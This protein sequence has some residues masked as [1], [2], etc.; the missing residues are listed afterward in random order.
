[1]SKITS[2]TSSLLLT[3]WCQTFGSTRKRRIV[4]RLPVSIC[5]YVLV[6]LLPFSASPVA[7]EP[8][9]PFRPS[10]IQEGLAGYWRLNEP[11]GNSPA[12]DTS[13]NG[14]TLATEGNPSIASGALDE[15]SRSFDG[16]DDLLYIDHNS[17]PSLHIHE[18]ATLFARVKLDSFPVPGQN[19]WGVIRKFNRFDGETFGWTMTL[20]RGDGNSTRV[21]FKTGDGLSSQLVGNLNLD[22]NRWYSIA[23]VVSGSHQQIYVDG[24]LDVESPLPNSVLATSRGFEIGRGLQSASYFD[25][26]IA[27]A[28][29]WDA[30]LTPEQI[31][32]LT[33]TLTG[34][35]RPN[36]LQVD[37]LRGYWPLNEI[38]GTG[39]AL[40]ESSH[41]NDLAPFGNPG[42]GEGRLD[43]F[44]R[45]FDGV[46]D[47]LAIGHSEAPSL[48][49][50]GAVTLFARINVARYPQPGENDWGIIEKFATVGGQRYGWAME[51]NRGNGQSTVINF[52]FGDGRSDSILG[53]TTLE[54]G[55]WYDIACV[56]SKDRLEIYV[57]GVLDRRAPHADATV[58][59]SG[60]FEIGNGRQ[61]TSYYS[62]AIA[63]AAVWNRALQPSEIRA[64]ALVDSPQSSAN[65]FQWVRQGGGYSEDYGLGIAT[66]ENGNVYSTGIFVG[67]ALFDQVE[68]TDTESNPDFDIF[69]AKYDSSGDIQWARKAGGQFSDQ[70]NGITSDASGNVYVT[71]F[72]RGSA[73]FES[74]TIVSSG[75]VDVF[76]AK[77]S[78]DGD[79]IWVRKAGGARSDAGYDIETDSGGNIYVSGTFYDTAMFGPISVSD[80]GFAGF[81]AK[82]DPSGEPVWVRKFGGPLSARAKKLAVDPSGNIVITGFFQGSAD[83]GPTTVQSAGED[84]VFV[85]KY[86]NMGELIWV[87]AASGTGHDGGVGI[88]TDQAGNIAVVGNITETTE[89][90]NVALTSKGP[91][92]GFLVKLDPDGNVLWVRQI[93]SAPYTTGVVFDGVGDMCVTGAFG[94]TVQFETT[95]LISNYGRDLFLAKYDS[96]GNFLN[97]LRVGDAQGHDIAIDTQGNALITG[98]AAG[99]SGALTFGDFQFSGRGLE[100]FFIAK[101][102]C[103]EP[104]QSNQPPTLTAIDP[105]EGAV[106]DVEF[107][108]SY[109]LHLGA[110]DAGDPDG[111][112]LQFRL[113]SIENGSL[114]KVGIEGVPGE[115]LLGPGEGWTWTPSPNANGLVGAFTITVWDGEL[116][117]DTPVLVQ[118]SVASVNDAPRFEKGSDLSVFEDAGLQIIPNWATEIDP[119]GRDD[120]DQ[121]L[122]FS[123]QVINTD[124]PNLFLVA[125]S[126]SADGILTYE[127]A[128]DASGQATMEVL[129]GDDG[130]TANGG[131]N[132]SDPKQF[133]ITVVPLNDAPIAVNTAILATEDILFQ[134]VLTGF[135]LEA[136]DLMF[137][138]ASN[139]AKG[140]VSI[141]SNS[142]FAY[143]PHDDLNGED[144]FTFTVNDGQL[145]SVPGTVSVTI[146]EVNDPP[147]ANP[148]QPGFVDSSFAPDFQLDGPIR[149]VAI[150]DDGRVLIGGD[151]T[152]IDGTVRIG[153]ARLNVDGSLDESFDPGLNVNGTVRTIVVAKNGGILV[154]G[155]LLYSGGANVLARLNPDGSWDSTFDWGP[156]AGPNGEIKSIAVQADGRILVA[157][158]F[159]TIDG[160]AT[161]AI[162]RLNTDGTVDSSFVPRPADPA[163]V[164]SVAAQ[165]D[166][167]VLIGGFFT[168]VQGVSRNRIARLNSDGSL[169][170]TFDPGDGA[171]SNIHLMKLQL[172]GKVLIGGHFST[173]DSITRMNVARLN[174]DGSLDIGFNPGSG[175]GFSGQRVDSILVL[176]G[177]KTLIGGTF[178]FF[179]GV[180]RNRIARL[181]EDG[182]VD[183]TYDIGSGTDGIVWAFALS[184][185][186]QPVAAG[187]FGSIDGNSRTG[188]GKLVNEQ[189]QKSTLEDSSLSFAASELTAN[190][191]TGPSDESGQTLTVISV[192]DPSSQG[193]SVTLLGGTI[194]Y[195]PAPEFNGVDS[196]AYSVTDDGTT[197]GSPDPKTGSSTVTIEVRSSNDP[198]DVSAIEDTVLHYTENDGAIAMTETVQVIDVDDAALVSATVA[199][200][201]NYARNQDI[202]EFTPIGNISGSFDPLSGA[203]TLEGADTLE[204]Y[205]NVLRS[206][207]YRNNS[208]NPSTL[209]RTLAFV[210]SDG[211]GV[212]NVAQR[213]IS[214]VSV[215]DRPKLTQ[216][217]PNVRTTYGEPLVVALAPDTFTDPEDGHALD[218]S[219]SGMP[220]GIHFDP[221]TRTFS[222]LAEV[223]DQYPIRVVAT[224]HGSPA[225]NEETFFT[226]DISKRLLD[227][228]AD[229]IGKTYDGTTTATVALSDDRIA[230][231]QL[232]ASYTAAS[233]ADKNVAADKP[234]TVTGITIS[235]PDAGNYTAG[236]TLVIDADIEPAGLTLTADAVSRSYGQSNPALTA[237]LSG[238]V[239]GESAGV[240]S[241]SPGFI[242]PT[243]PDSSVGSYPITP[244]LGSLTALNYIFTQFVGGTLTVTQAALTATAEDQSRTYRSSNPPLSIHYSGFENG[245]TEADLDS[246]PVASTTADIA[247]E[248]G[249]YS[250]TLTGGSDN[251]Y[252]LIL[253]NGE[254]S[255]TPATLLI[256]ADDK[257]KVY[258]AELPELTASYE[259]FVNGE[260]P[261]GLDTPV[262]FATTASAASSVGS[263]PITASEAQDANYAIVFENGELEVTKTLL[264]ATADDQ[265]RKYGEV[266]PEL[267]IT[268]SGFV[269]GDTETDVDT[270][271][272]ASTKATKT[273]P[274]DV[275]PITVNGGGDNNYELDLFP[276]S[277]RVAPAE[278][279][280]TADDA[281]RFYG[282]SNLAFTATISGFVNG[283]DASMVSG[284]PEFATLATPTS[285]ARDYAITPSLGTLS[286]E[287]YVF[288]NF[289]NGTLVVKKATLTATA[290]GKS[291]T[292]GSEN[293]LLTISY[294]GFVNGD[295]SALI[296]DLPIAS[297][298][299]TID[300]DAGIYPI[301]LSGGTDDN[302]TLMLNN[303][304]FSIS[305]ANLL[306]SADDKSNVYGVELPEL[307]ASYSG[308][309]NGDGPADLDTP[310]RL[311]TTASAASVVGSYP[312]MASDAQDANYAIVFEDG[313][314]DVTKV[315]LVTTA[316]GQSRKYGEINPELTITYSG[317]VNGDME[318]DIDTL[319][320]ASTLATIVS[321]VGSYPITLSGGEDHNYDLELAPGTLDVEAA[322]LTA[323]ADDATRVYGE[324]NRTFTATITGFVNGEDASVVSGSPEFSTLAT[325]TSP[326]G[327]YTI[328]PS[329]GTLSSRN[330]VFASFIDGTLVVNKAT[331]TATADDK[332]RIYGSENPLLTISYSGFVNGDTSVVLDDLP[333][334]STSATIDSDAGTYPIT[335]SGGADEDYALTLENGKLTITPGNLRI[336]ADDKSKVYGA[337]LPELTASFFGF[338]NGDGPS[339]LDTPVRPAT[340]ASA[341]SA[342]GG[343]PITASEAKDANYAI[344]FEDGELEV[345]KALLTATA[346]NQ[347]RKYGED[348]P[349]LTITY[350]GFV[351]GDTES[352]I[353]VL[354]I[355]ATSAITTSLVGSYPI[356][357]S[358]GEDNNYDLDRNPGNLTVDPAKLT[359][360]ADDTRRI[361]GE[362]NP[363]FT[364]TIS[365]FVNGEDESVVSGSAVFST[366]A[367]PASPAG[368]YAIT[369]S[370]GT[371]SAQNYALTSFVDGTLTV[372][373]AI[374]TA[375]ADGKS[376]TYGSENPPL[377]ISY[378]GF[379]NGN[380]PAELDV[381]PTASTIA[382][383]SSPVEDYPINLVGGQDDNY[384]LDLV[385]GILKVSPAALSVT[386]DDKTR[387]V[388]EPNPEFS[389]TI[390][391]FVNGEALTVVSGAPAFSTP[392]VQTG[393]AG[394][395][396]IAPLLGT[397]NSQNYVFSQ[398]VDGGLTV[399]PIDVLLD[400]GL[401]VN[402][403]ANLLNEGGLSPEAAQAV[404]QAIDN[405]IGNNGGQA[406][407]GATDQ[408]AL[409][410]SNAALV[411]LREAIQFLENAE[412]A[413]TSLDFTSEK[414][415]L[416]LTGGAVVDQ[417]IANGKQIASTPKDLQNIEAAESLVGVGRDLIYSEDFLGSINFFR[418][419]LTHLKSPPKGKKSFTV[420]GVRL[421][422]IAVS[423]SPDAQSFSFRA[424]APA[425]F[426]VDF[427]G[428]EDLLEWDKIRS[429]SIPPSGTADF[430]IDVEIETVV[431]FYRLRWKQLDL[432]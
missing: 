80:L 215:N 228:G 131:S 24:I 71:G 232:T 89:F 381:L 172:D 411:K 335:L 170:L 96:N 398:F 349:E 247:S 231:D 81:L 329:Q 78:A 224:D 301:T 7:A 146:S 332:S 140:A 33:T 289:V 298:T 311:A 353:N 37:Q 407:N 178:N 108:V 362:S 79:L 42:I 309:I 414:R 368:N 222:G 179:D 249:T 304:A 6:A 246:P 93:E 110:T 265:S 212:S 392:A 227:V 184:P 159:S 419:A 409:E 181:N 316:D 196:F 47:V 252:A 322:A 153:L 57:N 142:Q 112:S 278:L 124:N 187:E 383:D 279:T 104:V 262:R 20:N 163:V 313:E 165:P 350:S 283:E 157:G 374:L 44:S 399:R 188:V 406:S 371:L 271:P 103:G 336:S 340:T 343:Y 48:Q 293:P 373:K 272:T 123:V 194:H 364:T 144:I 238:F 52:K 46:D 149:A 68:L 29:V 199:I 174:S 95:S 201:E 255:I 61:P 118:I 155:G 30:T 334:A 160:K 94:G 327:D 397:L 17:A 396:P 143:S 307:T 432:E 372:N 193:G 254:L 223:A 156:G 413:D 15:W 331:L 263:Y 56:A 356:T 161:P 130:G 236:S 74:E 85:A 119:G 237:T 129:L 198:P 351:N 260:G 253:V 171:N 14:N 107:E 18:N 245:D 148:D 325:P 359:V 415:I 310:V 23:C 28:A 312:I 401:V 195:A 422:I 145:D 9:E 389:A 386:A 158:V 134:G 183:D 365:G 173:I 296:D 120:D 27:D 315:V 338:V 337:D 358:G 431:R 32:S 391:G 176:P 41:E 244:S 284:S 240:V 75:E 106:E 276:G 91:Q 352:D 151:F 164:M 264:T 51:A 287:N 324:A 214:I 64:L 36:Q 306:I 354:P 257:S 333:T 207:R 10:D 369:P 418:D 277:L 221:G 206:V 66:D 248:T 308:F 100:D 203:L 261:G 166:G 190:D 162:L 101:V 83:F 416:A 424:S 405:I 34:P 111:D 318:T 137:T 40:D 380:T 168:T 65:D 70:G 345:T 250:I 39:S 136:S 11:S 219:A 50:E 58:P 4:H 384:A 132:T 363:T 251:N 60:R 303:G 344:V 420:N 113:E 169:D 286:A 376:R 421:K 122:N 67:P 319:P 346:D 259:G 16:Q 177:G 321:P 90:G 243:S 427:E 367:T 76:I 280:V 268:Y 204:S 125:P 182:S 59:E 150:Q 197:N 428:S 400:L 357:L 209:T 99:R 62:G 92:D 282:Q 25:G 291:R 317:F 378:S 341:A 202:L 205:Q 35:L 382:D 403:L 235:G 82:Y 330:Y 426:V 339:D 370:L 1:M 285:P 77:Y 208:E 186:G 394:T 13:G 342:V 295:N 189:F 377:T 429:L 361:Y 12:S 395:Y 217:I 98:D 175:L 328:T 408:F 258:G 133:G 45:S 323:A 379:V 220:P 21:N 192:S 87:R 22:L 355:A 138:L 412:T 115:T 241:G 69:V 269:N 135:D 84:N 54:A 72:F 26:L 388:G 63:D 43:A 387:R 430:S 281:G 288:A 417:A 256:S 55:Q 210:V 239:N 147:I 191:L 410:N 290:D 425:G 105:L 275:Y 86:D 390:E 302:Y 347:S 300:S 117:S 216:S 393:P 38:V 230:G 152:T 273:S 229:G 128:V 31:K 404:Q 121:T 53:T 242:T 102:R 274:V 326:A 297:T 139:G 348:N 225:L 154:G 126:L 5:F 88:A 180:P 385:D 2:E 267:T 109:A 19:D 233:F 314:L 423:N 97:V 402:D 366:L 305:Q 320:I 299:A 116:G 200:E 127:A 218:Y 73:S 167:R 213:F 266:N 49:F 211:A 226:L 234:V 3:G 294:S 141:Q 114:S 375:T 270:P 360:T 185:D 8:A 292:Y